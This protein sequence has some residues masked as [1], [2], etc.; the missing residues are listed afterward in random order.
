MDRI[1]FGTSGWR[2]VIAEDF[3]FDNVRIASQAI[4]DYLKSEGIA[5]R[6]VIVG[7]DTRFLSEKFALTSALVLARNGIKVL[8]T[9]K[10]TPTPA[11][12]YETVRRK[13]AGSINITASHNPP[14]WNGLKFSPHWGGPATEDITSRIEELAEQIVRSGSIPGEMELKEAKGK[15]LFEEIDP[16]PFYL[17][18]IRELVDLDRI[19]NAAL[20][21]IVEPLYGTAVG[22]LDV[23]LMEAGCGVT[24]L[25]AERNP[26]FGGKPPEPAE[27]FLGDTIQAVRSSSAAL[28]LCTDGDADRFGIVDGDGSFIEPNYILALLLRYLIHSR[29]WKGEV[30]KTIATTHLLNRI[31]ERYGLPV[32][33]TAVGFKHLGRRMIENPDITIACEGSSGFTVRGHIPDKD[34]IL[35]CLLVAEMVAD[36]RRSLGEMLEDLYS[37][38]GRLVFREERIPM[39]IDRA[40]FVR[41]L[42]DNLPDRFGGKKVVKIDRTDGFKFILENGSWIGL[43]PSGTEP[44]VRCYMEASEEEELEAIYRDA[45]KLIESLMDSEA[46]VRDVGD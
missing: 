39:Q 12:G 37:E 35:T 17:D 7:Y 38:V 23:L 26:L 34:G 2:A 19:R 15:G 4:A 46:E 45:G 30:V 11:I 36:S 43:R 16:A 42:E 8:Y 40:S 22:Y 9:S 33:E 18:R 5:E 21:V 25:H 31:A 20:D 6:G 27:R 13:A 32:Y 24:L 41:S 10:A 44:L 1:K 14:E 28:G 29:G 3:T